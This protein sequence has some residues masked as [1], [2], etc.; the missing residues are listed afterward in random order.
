M[1]QDGSDM[2]EKIDRAIG[3][4]LLELPNLTHKTSLQLRLRPLHCIARAP[5]SL[6]PPLA[7]DQC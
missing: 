5:C 4:P 3:M 1:K 7:P 2:A 6:P